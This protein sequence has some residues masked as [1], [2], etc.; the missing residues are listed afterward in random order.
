VIA[1]A[2][3]P[4][5]THAQTKQ[6]PKEDF[7][8]VVDQAAA[9]LH[10]INQKSTAEFQ[11]K[12]RALKQKRAW[13]NEAFLKAAAGYVRDETIVGFEEKTEDLLARLN[14]S[15]TV[16]S[17]SA[18]CRTLDDLKKTMSDLVETQREKWKYM[19]AKLDADL[20]K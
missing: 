9:R 1:L 15:G 5:S 10:E 20:A 2:L 12:L 13:S 19:F 14:A 17:A 16:Q 7:E 8:A 6:C 11:T 4:A 3:I 18:D